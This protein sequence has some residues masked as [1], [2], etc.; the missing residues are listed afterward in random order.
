M[1]SNSHVNSITWVS[2]S[3]YYEFCIE[4]CRGLLGGTHSQVAE[5]TRA[6]PWVEVLGEVQSDLA[7]LAWGQE[8][9]NTRI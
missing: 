4:N 1:V 2:S 7:D 9:K 8:R 6:I 3:Q 5:R